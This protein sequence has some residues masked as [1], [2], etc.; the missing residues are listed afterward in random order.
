MLSIVLRRSRYARIEIAFNQRD[1]RKDKAKPVN[2]RTVC[3]FTPLENIAGN[4]SVQPVINPG[5]SRTNA[6]YLIS[7]G[8]EK[9]TLFKRIE[10]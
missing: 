10:L 9:H 5:V 2:V 6:Y 4:N 8:G 1:F 7:N 3:G